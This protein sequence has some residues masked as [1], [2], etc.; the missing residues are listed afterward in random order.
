M[1]QTPTKLQWKDSTTGSLQCTSI[2]NRIDF[3]VNGKRNRNKYRIDDIIFRSQIGRLH[4]TLS[5][6]HN[7]KN[8]L[9][10][11]YC[12]SGDILYIN[13]PDQ[14]D[15]HLDYKVIHSCHRTLTFP[16]E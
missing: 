14:T 5:S 6:L 7:K 15:I 16:K 2:P 13:L 8:L 4:L 9:P 11:Q 12:P 3:L 1:N 10:F